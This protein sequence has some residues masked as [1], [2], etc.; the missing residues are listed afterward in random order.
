MSVVWER[1]VR[2]VRRGLK[3]ILG[4]EPMNEEVLSIVFTEAERIANTR[5]LAPNS[6][7]PGESEPLTPSHFLNL[8]SS[9]NIPPDVVSE[10]DKFS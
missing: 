9:T 6:S 4:K 5:P 1:L 2:T 8:R 3:V 7:C 10:N